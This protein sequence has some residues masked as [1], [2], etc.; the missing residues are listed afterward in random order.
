M[1]VVAAAVVVA[2]GAADVVVAST[3]GLVS[4]ALYTQGSDISYDDECDLTTHAIVEVTVTVTEEH[5]VPVE[6]GAVEVDTAGSATSTPP[7]T[8]VPDVTPATAALISSAVASGTRRFCE[9]MQPMVSSASS[10][11]FP[12]AVGSPIVPGAKVPVASAS[13][14]SPPTEAI[15]LASSRTMALLTEAALV[16]AGS[17]EV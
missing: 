14:G 2:A 15:C 12:L 4:A 9:T 11:V 5:A 16:D 1:E 17:C 10:Q 3:A 6:A 13:C 7:P 8:L